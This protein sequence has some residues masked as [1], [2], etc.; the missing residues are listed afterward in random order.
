MPRRW[1]FLNLM[2]AVLACGF[3]IGLVREV[4]RSRSLP[5]PP[6]ARGVSTSAVAS[7]APTRD[8]RPP[9]GLPTYTVIAA[10]NLFSAARTEATAA[11]PVPPGPKPILHGVVLDGKKSRAYLEDPAAKRVFGYAVGDTVSGGRL[12][13]ISED[14]VVIQRPEGITEVLLQDPSKP[15]PA[16]P[17]VPVAQPRP[18]GMPGPS[19]APAQV[20]APPPQ[21]QAGQPVETTPQLRRR[22]GPGQPSR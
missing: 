7:G 6:A 9:A 8:S 10:K 11:V 4:P 3:A 13:Q 12:E 21:P 22:P 15:R 1:L 16:G 18:P 5:P 17:A 20:G 19:P 14:R 2:L